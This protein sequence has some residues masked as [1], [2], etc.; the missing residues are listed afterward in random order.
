VGKSRN[1]L[2]NSFICG[3]III[4]KGEIYR[5]KNKIKSYF[6]ENKIEY[7]GIIDYKHCREINKALSD[8]IGFQPKSVIVFLIPYYAGESKNISAYASSCDY[9]I[10]V[11]EITTG[12]I[13]ALQECAGEYNYAGFGDHSPIDERHAA[14]LAGLGV[15]GKN[16][17]LI[18]EK[19]GS[20]VFIAEVITDAPPAALR[21]SEPAEIFH[22]CECGQCSGACPT[23]HISNSENRCLS[24]I[25]QRK[26]S[27]SENELELMRK[28]DTVWG[29]DL[30]QAVCP[31]N[32]SVP[33]TPIPFFYEHRIDC[34]NRELLDSFTDEEFKKR[35]FAWRGRKTIERNLSIYKKM[36]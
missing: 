23:G 13:Q 32:K 25:T 36:L 16:G 35:A 12:L 15:L 29:C 9:H 8:R 19:Y 3:K 28:V 33:K 27:L 1:I 14:L 18:N 10:F 6:E 30:C 21:A 22:C 20:Y 26:G 17:L 4:R 24:E 7:F 34:L 31:H 2:Q 11:K 5:M